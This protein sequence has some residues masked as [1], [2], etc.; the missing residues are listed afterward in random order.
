MQPA[1]PL[2]STLPAQFS[3]VAITAEPQQEPL[4][5]FVSLPERPLEIVLQFLCP[6]EVSALAATNRTVKESLKLELE[7]RWE[8]F[9]DSKSHLDPRRSQ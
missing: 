5:E 6:S 1:F 3:Y 2:S 8:I 9:V 7:L 4:P